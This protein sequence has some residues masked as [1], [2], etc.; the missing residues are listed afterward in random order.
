MASGFDWKSVV[1]QLVEVDKASE[2][3]DTMAGLYDYFDRRLQESTWR[4]RSSRSTI[5]TIA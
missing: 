1:D 3:G 4:K 2:F 5:F